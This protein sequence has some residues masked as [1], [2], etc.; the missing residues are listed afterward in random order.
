MAKILLVEDDNNL[1]EIYQARMMAEGYTIVAAHDGEEALA[2][3]AKEKPDLI[4]SDVMMPK[5]SGFEML[6][7]LRNTQGL[8]DT[9]VIMLTAL[10]QAED[11]SRADA[12]GADRYLVKSQ[13]TLEDIVTAAQELLNNTT[14]QSTPQTV[15]PPRPAVVPVA[16][17]PATATAAPLQTPAPAPQTPQ[18]TPVVPSTPA[19]VAA[20]TVPAKPVIPPTPPTQSA[21]QEST[22]VQN[23]IAN[24]ENQPVAPAQPPAPVAAATVPAKPVIPPTPPRPAVVPVAQAPATATAAPLQTPAPAP[25]TPQSTPVVPASTTTTVA[26]APA[27]AASP[28]PTSA[29]PIVAD[30]KLVTDAVNDLMEK[31]GD[32]AAATAP[33]PVITPIT[34]PPTDSTTPPD[35]EQAAPVPTPVTEPSDDDPSN[36][37]AP[38]ARKKIIT[39]ITSEASKSNLSSLL[40]AEEASPTVPAQTDQTPQHQPGNVF[41]PTIGTGNGTGDSTGIDP[42]SISL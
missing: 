1:S 28:V 19:P 24:F 12:L 22:T 34:E 42:N 13:V 27:P 9:K 20:A 8:K 17:A 16:Q 37:S 35:D 15:T 29:N 2:V 33:A 26:T 7:I 32:T 30:D 40:A 14:V 25:Q 11:K 38:V 3:A 10:G 18:S 41:T 39:P 21:Q 5:I 36:D 4:I 31:A 23:Q 6:D